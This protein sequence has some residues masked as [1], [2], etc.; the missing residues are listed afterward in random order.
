MNSRKVEGSGIISSKRMYLS[1]HKLY[2]S[3]FSTLAAYL[4]QYM[5]DSC[6]RKRVQNGGISLG[7]VAS[8]HNLS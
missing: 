2:S 1:T 3:A 4:R 5:V 7:T 8:G 6:P